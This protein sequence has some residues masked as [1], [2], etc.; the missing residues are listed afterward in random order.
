MRRNLP[1]QALL[2]GQNSLQQLPKQIT[3]IHHFNEQGRGTNASWTLVWENCAETNQKVTNDPP[4]AFARVAHLK[5]LTCGSAACSP[6]K[7]AVQLRFRYNL[8]PKL[9]RGR[10]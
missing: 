9:A 8:R 1:W 7:M 2:Y 6:V 5:G 4:Q 10:T 3:A